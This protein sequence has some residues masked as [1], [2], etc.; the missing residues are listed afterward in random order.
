MVSLGRNREGFL[1]FRVSLRFALFRCHVFANVK[2]H[3]CVCLVDALVSRVHW[4]ATVGW[5]QL[6]KEIGFCVT[7]EL[8]SVCCEKV[9]CTCTPG[10]VFCFR[11]ETQRDG[12]C[13]CVR[14]RLRGKLQFFSAS[15]FEE[16][17]RFPCHLEVEQWPR[18]A[19]LCSTADSDLNCGSLS[20][21]SLS[22]SLVLSL[23]WAI[24]KIAGKCTR[25]CGHGRWNCVTF[26]LL[27]L[28][29]ASCC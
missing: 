4:I 26:F 18:E 10:H 3:M 25:L 15:L 23:A 28:T 16:K 29:G 13:A 11:H 22:L 2:A 19:S 21:L 9:S 6:C 17:V 24:L 14:G 5:C 27:S 20:L 1:S 7:V 12:H 8:L